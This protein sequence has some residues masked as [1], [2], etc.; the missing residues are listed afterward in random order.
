MQ[1]GRVPS[2]G[3]NADPV[4][5]SC[6]PS[7]VIPPPLSPHSIHPPALS[8]PP[9]SAPALGPRRRLIETRTGAQ[10]PILVYSCT[11]RT[12]HG[13]L[14]SLYGHHKP[15]HG[16]T[17]P[18][19]HTVG[20]LGLEAYQGRVGHRN[21]A[22]PSAPRPPA[23]SPAISLPGGVQTATTRPLVEPPI[24]LLGRERTSLLQGGGGGRIKG[25]RAV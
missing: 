22:P 11:L 4:L 3:V 2:A 15:D 13:S 16:K 14:H 17:V 8:P 18:H 5:T 1:R 23:V 20:T 21:R 10:A 25:L 7:G 12:S 6:E 9:C 24:S 19:S